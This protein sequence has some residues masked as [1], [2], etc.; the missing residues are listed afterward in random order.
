MVTETATLREHFHSLRWRI[1]RLI[2][3]VLLVLS[4]IVAFLLRW[5]PNRVDNAPVMPLPAVTVPLQPSP[6]SE[7]PAPTSRD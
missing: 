2:A 7:P 4:A 1:L 5:E 3:A 6:I